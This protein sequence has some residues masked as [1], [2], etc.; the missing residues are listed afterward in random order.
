MTPQQQIQ[1]NKIAS[2]VCAKTGI[3][4]EQIQ[5]RDK[6]AEVSL[7]RQIIWTVSK[8]LFGGKISLKE[9]GQQI[10]D[11]NHSTVTFAIKTVQGY[12]KTDRHFRALYVDILKAAQ[13][14]AWIVQYKEPREAVKERLHDVLQCSDQI[15]MRIGIREIISSLNTTKI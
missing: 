13:R 4:I 5:S 9:L 2:V 15:N 3:T 7:A 12:I 14:S 6:T 10:G 1:I 11:R 8:E